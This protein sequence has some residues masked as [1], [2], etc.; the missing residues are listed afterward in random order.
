MLRR[1]DKVVLGVSGGADSVCLL[2]VLSALKKEL[3]IELSVAHINHGVRAEAGGDAAYVEQLCRELSVP[4]YLK[5]ICM[6]ELA[7]E[8]RCSSEEAGRKARYAFFEEIC[9]LIGAEK[10]AVAHNMGDCSETVLFHLFR[11]SGLSGLSGI[12]PV[13]DNVIRPILCLE[14]REIE[15][16]L[17]A[18]GLSYRH[19]VTN[20]GDDYTRN[21]IR[22]HILPY[23][24]AEIVTGAAKNVYEA[25]RQIAQTQDFVE[26]QVEHVWKEVVLSCTEEC[27]EL[28]IPRFT[29]L[30]V[31]LQKG[32]LRKAVA[33]L[34]LG[35]KDITREHLEGL[36]S[37]AQHRGNR[38]I[39]LPGQLRGE[40][41]YERLIIYKD[42]PQEAQEKELV[43]DK[44]M[45]GEEPVT[46]EF[47]GAWITL[48][49]TDFSGNLQD[50]PQNQ[51]TKWLNCDKIKDNLKIRY[52]QSGDYFSLK[53]DTGLGKKKLKDFF[54][55]EKI[56]RKRRDELIL[57]AEGNHVLWL[58]GYRI[59][60]YYKVD[61]KTQKVLQITV[62]KRWRKYGET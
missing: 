46:V 51:Y 35:C 5:E 62:K 6:E 29:G 30:H 49:V 45:L 42:T 2:T 61:E 22:H 26:I 24:E 17:L 8:W 31:V 27:I 40:R 18:K 36:A 23:A 15:Q 20:D 54:M 12:R 28:D 1:G 19:D 53:K 34:V 33:M 58:T 43:I 9:R 41:S 47:A 57:I 60:E 38:Q 59:S 48:N 25:A 4:F 13:R 39:Y 3:G 7:R 37:L 52:R 10:I 55:D 32:I 56:P 14:R 44:G 11:G 21:R 16:Y 50:I